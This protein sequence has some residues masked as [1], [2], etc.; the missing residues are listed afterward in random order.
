VQLAVLGIGTAAVLGGIG[1]LIYKKYRKSKLET[2]LKKVIND[3]K[4]DTKNTT[5]TETQALDFANRLFLAMDSNGTDEKAIQAI[6][7]DRNLTGDDIKLIVKKF[8]IKPYGITGTPSFWSFGTS[9]DLDLMGW[10]REEL[11]EYWLKQ[12]RPKFDAAGFTL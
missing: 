12:M 9:R 10:L 6:L 1:W 8:G 3:T 5:I 11:S 2:D 7:I 4:V